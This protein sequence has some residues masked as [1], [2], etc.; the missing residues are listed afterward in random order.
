MVSGVGFFVHLCNVSIAVKSNSEGDNK[1]NVKSDLHYFSAS[2]K[3]N[4]TI[5]IIDGK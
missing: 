4:A 3:K 5:S 1:T 2:D